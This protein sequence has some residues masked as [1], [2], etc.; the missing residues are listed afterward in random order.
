MSKIRSKIIEPPKRPSDDLPAEELQKAWN[1]Y[2]DY[3]LGK[4]NMHPR[5]EVLLDPRG[6]EILYQY[7]NIPQDYM[8]MELS[9]KMQAYLQAL[10]SAI[11]KLAR[12]NFMQAKVLKGFFGI[13]RVEPLTQ[14]QMADKFIY[15]SGGRVTQQMV[16]KY[17][18]AAK[19]N[20]KALIQ[21]ELE[22]MKTTNGCTST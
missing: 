11:V 6:L 17:L 3:Y 21:E 10:E 14:Q 7:L 4:P 13:G 22:A 5:W 20:L 16:S 15:P 19:R 8:K 12:K 9:P 18:K 2:L 1:L